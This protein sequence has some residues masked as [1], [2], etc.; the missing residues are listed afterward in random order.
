[1]VM[2]AYVRSAFALSNGTYGSPRMTRELQ[3][4]GFAIGRRRTARLMRENDLRGRPTA[5]FLAIHRVAST[6]AFL[7]AISEG[8]EKVGWCSM[9]ILGQDFAYS[10]PRLEARTRSICVHCDELRAHCIAYRRIRR[11]E[12]ARL[13][14]PEFLRD[15]KIF[16]ASLGM[17]ATERLSALVRWLDEARCVRF[18]DRR[19]RRIPL[20]LDA[21]LD[22]GLD[23]LAEWMVPP[24]PGVIPLVHAVAIDRIW[25]MLTLV[26]MKYSRATLNWGIRP[27]QYA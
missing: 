22:A 12:P 15:A 21:L 27:K 16:I 23:W 9:R 5:D 24:P 14:E 8:P 20:D 10:L 17:S 11:V 26:R 25:P 3:D 2:P 6:S 13:D 1:M 4:D 19:G 18:I 7:D